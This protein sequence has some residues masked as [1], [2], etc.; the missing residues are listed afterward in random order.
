MNYEKPEKD[1]Q[2]KATHENETPRSY[3]NILPVTVQRFTVKGF[4]RLV[5]NI[6]NELRCCTRP[7]PELLKKRFGITM[8]SRK[9]KTPGA[10][11]RK[12]ITAIA[13][14]SAFKAACMVIFFHYD[15]KILLT[16]DKGC[17]SIASSIYFGTCEWERFWDDVQEFDMLY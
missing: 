4:F 3:S 17:P 13:N 11:L 10:N 12:R 14:N 5:S 6:T 16:S 2:N 15:G 8:K 9:E 1:A 7:M